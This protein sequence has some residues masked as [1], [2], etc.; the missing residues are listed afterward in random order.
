MAAMKSWVASRQANPAGVAPETVSG[1]EKWIG[2]REGLARQTRLM[3]VS[4]RHTGW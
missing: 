4:T 3:A 2:E 1:F